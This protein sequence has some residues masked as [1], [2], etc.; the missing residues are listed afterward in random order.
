MSL[1][2]EVKLSE[3]FMD[4]QES[5]LLL[6]EIIKEFPLKVE[7]F[8]NGKSAIVNMFMGEAIKGSGGSINPR[9][10]KKIIIE[11]LENKI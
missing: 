10:A 1:Y 2:S 3:Q 6:K 9:N 4:N 8:N 11:I 7:E 5:E